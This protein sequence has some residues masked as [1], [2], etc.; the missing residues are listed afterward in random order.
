MAALLITPASRALPASQSFVILALV[1]SS[2]AIVHLSLRHEVTEAHWLIALAAPSLPALLLLGTLKLRAGLLARS[3]ALKKD[4]ACSLCGAL[5]SLGVL[6]SLGATELHADLWWVDA[7]IALLVSLGLL[8]HGA[9]TLVKSARRRQRW[10]TAAWWRRAVGDAP[11]LNAPGCQPNRDA[12]L[13]ASLAFS[14]KRMAA[15]Q[16]KTTGTPSTASSPDSQ[17]SEEQYAAV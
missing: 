11:M 16:H 2:T 15:M 1:V 9:F 6:V 3:A 14:P 5:L 10:W 7:A 12:A 4:G 17:T 8:A 13:V